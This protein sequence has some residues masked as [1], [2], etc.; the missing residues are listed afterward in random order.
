MK[1]GFRMQTSTVD[2]GGCG[3][4]LVLMASG[5]FTEV[6]QDRPCSIELH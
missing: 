4:D 6:S 2:K 1:M 5:D 3:F